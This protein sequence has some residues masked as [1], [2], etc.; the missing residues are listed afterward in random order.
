MQT[1]VTELTRDTVPLD[2]QKLTSHLA[3]VVSQ[4]WGFNTTS[5]TAEEGRDSPWEIQENMKS[6][7]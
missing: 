2:A 1:N 7:V 3:T 4:Y 6:G 5:D